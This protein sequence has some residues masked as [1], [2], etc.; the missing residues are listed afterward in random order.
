LPLTVEETELKAAV[1]DW[2]ELMDSVRPKIR[3]GIAF[4]KS[5]ES[6][7]A[8]AACGILVLIFLVTEYRLELLSLRKATVYWVLYTLVLTGIFLAL[9][10]A[11]WVVANLFYGIVSVFV[12]I[13]AASGWLIRDIYARGYSS[14]RLAYIVFND[15]WRQANEYLIRHRRWYNSI[16]VLVPVFFALSGFLVFRKWKT[17]TGP[18]HIVMGALLVPIGLGAG[19]EPR[20]HLPLPLRDFFEVIALQRADVRFERAHLDGGEFPAAGRRPFPAKAWVHQ[21][22]SVE[23]LNALFNKSGGF[24]LDVVSRSWRSTPSLS[25]RVS[26]AYAGEP[27]R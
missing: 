2:L 9:R 10:S 21:T 27:A 22:N 24:E 15:D 12:Y 16:V 3:E 4:F 26:C 6:W 25:A 11:N 19:V 20:I 7:R 8:A 18:L 14:R 23:K 17:R 1:K 13:A 5:A